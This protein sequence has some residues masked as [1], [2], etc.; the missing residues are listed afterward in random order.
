[1]EQVIVFELVVELWSGP[2]Y[3]AVELVVEELT[4]RVWFH[5]VLAPVQLV[6][7]ADEAVEDIFFLLCW[8]AGNS[9]DLMWLLRTDVLE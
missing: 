2:C 8:N 6:H 3:Q 9:F 4:A 5:V 7:D 1:M